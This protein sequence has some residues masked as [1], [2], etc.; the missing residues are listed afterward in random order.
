MLLHAD[1]SLVYCEN[2]ESMLR[3]GTSKYF[4]LKEDSVG[5]PHIYLS[6]STGKV[7]LENG[8]DAWEFISNQNVKVNVNNVKYR[9]QKLDKKLPSRVETPLRTESRTE[10]DVLPKLVPQEVTYY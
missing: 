1:D 8:V 5:P 4:E 3:N 2:D 10:L 6:G 9:L 7:E